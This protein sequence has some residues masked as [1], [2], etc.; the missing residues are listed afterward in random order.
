[1]VWET[2]KP[3]PPKPMFILIK[4]FAQGCKTG[5]ERGEG[6]LKQTRSKLSGFL[7]SSQKLYDKRSRHAER[8]K[9]RS[10]KDHK[11]VST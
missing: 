6:A 1:M 4:I 7:K 8:Y 3:K 10:R 5:G 11:Y 9:K 2:T